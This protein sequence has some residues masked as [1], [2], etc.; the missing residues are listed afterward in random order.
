MPCLLQHHAII[1]DLYKGR[2]ILFLET[3]NCGLLQKAERQLRKSR[4]SEM[5]SRGAICQFDDPGP[6]AQ[7]TGAAHSPSVKWEEQKRPTGHE[8]FGARR[9]VA[10]SL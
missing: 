2:A 7:L 8:H 10:P 3:G 4:E 6:G 5:G 9:Q 1:S